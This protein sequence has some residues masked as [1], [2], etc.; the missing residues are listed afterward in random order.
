MIITYYGLNTFKVQFGDT[1]LAINPSSKGDGR[2]PVRFGSDIT[3][4]SLWH[5]DFNATEQNESKGKTPIVIDGPGE[6]EVEGLTIAGISSPADYDGISTNTIYNVSMEGMSLCFLGALSSGSLDSNVLEAI[7][8]VDILFTPIGGG[9]V[10]DASSAYKLS[11][12]LE[13]KIVIP[14]YFKSLKDPA[15]K[16]FLE[17]GGE[18]D[19][20]P[21]EKFTVK[22][23][24]VESKSGE[25]VVLSFS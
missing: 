22:K 8:G 17:E 16:K 13:P 19:I 4:V 12:K 10:L 24:D 2:S 7:D 9:S 5:P 20:R 15:L 14:S 3:L 11:V 25:I 1:V 21:M 23:K 18:D 6:Y